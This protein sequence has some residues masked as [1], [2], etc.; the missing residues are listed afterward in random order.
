MKSDMNS[1]KSYKMNQEMTPS[2]LQFL[3]MRLPR[4]RRAWLAASLIRLSFPSVFAQ[5]EFSSFW[6]KFKSVVVAG[7]KTAVADMTKFPLSMPYEVKP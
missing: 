1:T 6:A 3:P 2:L 4:R 5:G 7:D